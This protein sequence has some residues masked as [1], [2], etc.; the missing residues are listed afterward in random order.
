MEGVSKEI[1]GKETEL[2]IQGNYVFWVNSD[3][4]LQAQDIVRRGNFIQ[5]MNAFILLISAS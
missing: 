5:G 1:C 4:W 3:L 2:L